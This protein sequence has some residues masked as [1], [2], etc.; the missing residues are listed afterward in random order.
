MGACRKE[1]FECGLCG[2][3]FKLLENLEMHLQ[4][5]EIYECQ[6]LSCWLRGVDISEMKK[7]IG[8]KHSSTTKLNYLKMGREKQHIVCSNSYFLKDL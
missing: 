6:S 8:E 1:N 7:H 2:E 5:C 4:T 3:E